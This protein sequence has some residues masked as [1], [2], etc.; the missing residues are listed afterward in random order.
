[1]SQS[2]SQTQS[3]MDM[4]LKYQA[5]EGRANEIYDTEG[6]IKPHWQYLL[7]SLEAMDKSTLEDRHE[8]AH[9]ILRDDGATYNIY[10]DSSEGSQT[11]ALDLIPYIIG[12]EEWSTIEAGLA[13]RAELFNLL[14]KDIY[15]DREL[16]RS[17]VIP[18]EALFM[19]RGFLRACHGINI[20]S[21]HHLIHHAVD[22]MRD[23]SGQICVL[24]DRT[25]APSGA[26]YALENRTVMSRVFPSLFRDSHVHRLAGF[27]QRY[28]AALANLAPHTDEPRIVLLT[29]GMHNETAFEH[30]YVANYLGL[31]LVQS[32]DLVVRDNVVYMKSLDGLSR[33]DVIVRRVDDWYCDPVELRSDSH[34]GIAALIEAARAGNVAIANPLG[35]GILENPIF[36]RYL[37]EIAK[38]LLGRELR[39]PSVNTYWC[40]NPDDWAYVRANVNRLVFKP[41]DR[42][43]M[44][45]SV[46]GAQL[47]HDQQ[48]ELLARI[49]KNPMAYVAQDVLKASLIPAYSDHQL[50]ARP[51]IL[52]SFAVASGS[53]YTVMPGGLTRV[54]QFEDSFVISNQVGA[55][56]KDTWILASEPER[57]ISAIDNDD[58]ANRDADLIS[59]PSRV[60]E[61]LFWMGRYAERAEA[62]LRILRT[63]FVLL[64]SEE[65][66]SDSCKPYLFEAVTA[67]TG[68]SPGFENANEELLANPEPELVDLVNNP[69]RMGSVRNNLEAM[70]NC[71]DQSKELLSSD[72]LRQINDVRDALCTLDST[73]GIDLTSAP[74]E[75]LDPLVTSLVAIAGLIQESMLRGNGWRFIQLG[76]KLERA[77]QTSALI[78]TLVVPEVPEADQKV[79]IEAMLISSEGLIS[80]RRRYRGKIGV[81]SSLDLVM[82]DPT[83]PRSLVYQLDDLKALI[84]AIP[85]QAEKRHELNSELR[86]VIEAQTCVKLSLLTELSAREDGRRQ[87]LEE[88]LSRVTS[89]LW[90]LSTFVSDK[91]FSHRESAQQL[92][93]NTGF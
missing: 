57:Q 83:N 1:M 6:N 51:A 74:E 75:A 52:R 5:A 23:D 14:L 7:G 13:E 68:T 82:M 72:M 65:P 63:V 53:S 81:Q 9:R 58:S 71:A 45:K 25:Q 49:E 32:G 93:S 12:S 76:R 4:A 26:G 21:D 64:N 87:N 22:L 34:L 18:P 42:S 15:G 41:I 84:E 50:Q 80:H 70:V 55:L 37:P 44:I 20:Q 54:G 73:L 35:S 11:W 2:Q 8:T 67:V 31:H 62:S 77:L 43:T 92:V 3:P 91:Y 39:I 27:F 30:A 10:G 40:A 85:K 79:L 56:S 17:G 78:K 33:V 19:H 66:L 48:R 69:L 60:I 36:S 24:T 90:S 61:N 16:I 88:T 89:L 29:P 28:R 86:A 59:L 46:S 38:S 47:S